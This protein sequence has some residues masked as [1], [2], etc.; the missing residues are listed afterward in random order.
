MNEINTKKQLSN[1]GNID[2]PIAIGAMGGSGTRIVAQILIESGIFLGDDLNKA[3]DNLWF[4]RLFKDPF[5]FKDANK[6]E[7]DSR[8]RIFEKLM[9]KRRLNKKE[10]KELYLASINNTTFRTK[11]KELLKVFLKSFT[12]SPSKKLWGWKEPNTHLYIKQLSDYFKNL[13][14]IHVIR[15]GLDMA[16]AKNKQQL[17]NWGDNFGI[18]P[19]EDGKSLPYFQLEYWIRSNFIAIENARSIL[20]DRFYLLYFDE[21]CMNPSNEIRRIFNFLDIPLKKEL[22]SYLI[23]IPKIPKTSGRYKVKDLSLFTK[24]QLIQIEK[25][26]FSI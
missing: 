24:D 11:K 12:F 25:L 22:F 1:F 4:T 19:S 16:F 21:L 18:L 8:L 2:H 26:G 6:N 13:K 10:L 5:W 17:I 9:T 20:N 7:L 3:N 14:Y 15:H 23:T